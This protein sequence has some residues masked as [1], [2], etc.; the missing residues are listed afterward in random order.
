MPDL[1]ESSRNL[2]DLFETWLHLRFFDSLPCDYRTNNVRV[3][4]CNQSDLQIGCRT[5]RNVHSFPANTRFFSVFCFSS[6]GNTYISTS[7]LFRIWSIL[8]TKAVENATCHPV[9]NFTILRGKRGSAADMSDHATVLFLSAVGGSKPQRIPA[10]A[11]G[12]YENRPQRH[13]DSV[14]WR[15]MGA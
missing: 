12:P 2:V 9:T 5:G 10:T 7:S 14:C 8:T 6:L 1:Q 15:P 3:G 13:S 11:N 4:M